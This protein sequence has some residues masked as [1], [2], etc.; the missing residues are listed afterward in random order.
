MTEILTE[1]FCE[2]C[3]SRYT[4]ESAA[5]KIKMRRAKVLTR[6]LKNFVLDDKTSL[7]EA[8][9]AARSDTDREVTTSQ[10]DAFHQTFNFCMQCRQ[11][12]CPNCWND[13]E[14]R[15][16][17]CAPLSLHAPSFAETIGANGATPFT[18]PTNGAAAASTPTP[19]L[20]GAAPASIT[21]ATNGH[22]DDPDAFD[23][24]ARLNALSM[25]PAPAEPAAPVEPATPVEAEA[26]EA[27]GTPEPMLAEAAPAE[28]EPEPDIVL[29]LRAEAAGL[30]VAE[31]FGADETLQPEPEVAQPI[32]FDAVSIEATDIVTPAVP[33]AIDALAP[34]VVVEPLAAEPVASEPVAPEPVA[35]EP[36]ASAPVLEP[37]I[38]PIVEAAEPE[39]VI[40][41]LDEL[42]FHPYDIDHEAVD[43]LAAS[44]ALEDV[45]PPAPEPLA[46]E[47][48][49]S[50][51]VVGEPIAAEHD[52]AAAAAAAAM[53][54]GLRP[55][56]S[57][58]DA[59]DEFERADAPAQDGPADA[60]QPLD[61]ASVVPEPVT[62]VAP[63]DMVV[64]PVPAVVAPVAA[65]PVAAPPEPVA[66]PP[67][68]VAAQPQPVQPVQPMPQPIPAAPT[69]PSAPAVDIVAQP[70]WTVVAPEPTVAPAPTNGTPVA[71]VSPTPP[72][73]PTPPTN[74]TTVAPATQTAA[75]EWP[76]QPQWPA[77]QES[78]GLPFLGRPAVPTGGVEALWAASDQ[79]VTAAPTTDRPMTGVQSCVSC[80]LSLSA[81]ARFC[82]RCGTAQHA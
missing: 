39:P 42:V 77:Q 36:V 37:E 11:Y 75:P 60:V 55:G 4:F 44:L 23:P 38:I 81:T 33:A 13:A 41:P 67:E 54:A 69:P 76:A 78:V 64:E 19:P 7:D 70:T 1:S 40:E 71:P 15:C 59:L 73:A 10:L 35:P 8:M 24:I 22:V 2:R 52:H 53:V 49:A 14:G 45:A 65:E 16:L 17:T 29:D 20:A 63:A 27:L 61:I 79:E 12:T 68:P 72:V 34:P 32:A 48:A 28:P 6:G 51:P 5:P 47:P 74:G 31:A 80:G 57:L 3:G 50:E 9:A 62:E 56:Q 43:A 82:R 21:A 46:T 30:G 26:P 58:D 66:A 18:V 25:A